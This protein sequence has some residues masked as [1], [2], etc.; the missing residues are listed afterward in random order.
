[1]S[2]YETTIKNP[3]KIAEFYK[4]LSEQKD[5]EI[6][7]LKEYL[8]RYEA[9]IF[10]LKEQLERSEKARKEAIELIKSK[11]YVI[12][13]YTFGYELDDYDIFKVKRILNIDKGE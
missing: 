4:Q 12:D 11:E 3:K 5:I 10:N 7:Q 6:K 2:I 9:L 13:L 1:M 8:E